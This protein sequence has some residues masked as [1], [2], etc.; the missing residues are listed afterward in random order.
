MYSELRWV[1]GFSELR[2]TQIMHESGPNPKIPLTMN[3]LNGRA[4]SRD[5]M[6]YSYSTY[7]LV[8]DLAKIIVRIKFTELVQF[9]HVIKY[10]W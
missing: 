3:W 8:L 10:C 6:A 1:F 7:V 5:Q 4:D 9:N 2:I